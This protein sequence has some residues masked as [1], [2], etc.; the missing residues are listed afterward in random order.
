LHF[1]AIAVLPLSKTEVFVKTR[2]AATAAFA[3]VLISIVTLASCEKKAPEQGQ[4]AGRTT[5][6]QPEERG[7]RNPDRNAYFGEEH[8][9][10][11]G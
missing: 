6:A 3:S 7:E 5:T 10:T 4:Q 8:I 1:C 11:P 9:H 2:V